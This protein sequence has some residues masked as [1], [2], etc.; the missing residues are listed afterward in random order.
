[1]LMTALTL[2]HNA[3]LY[4]SVDPKVYL[5]LGRCFMEWMMT[6]TKNVDVAGNSGDTEEEK[7]FEEE[8]WFVG[9][10]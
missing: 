5:W 4:D 1:M 10:V 8:E 7:P 2:T 9:Q 3:H 6:V